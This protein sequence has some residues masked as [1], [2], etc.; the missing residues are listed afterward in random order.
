VSSLSSILTPSINRSPSFSF[1]FQYALSFTRSGLPAITHVDGSARVQTV[2]AE[3]NPRFA[4]LLLAFYERTGCPILL[5]TSFN[6]RGEP[7]VCSAFDAI[8]CFLRCS[9]DVVIVEDFALARRHVNGFWEKQLPLLL[10]ERS[11]V[12]LGHQVYTL[13]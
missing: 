3:T 5:N 13:L 4:A 6:M 7:I 1:F 8:R 2:D 11:G 10:A 12:A 9:I